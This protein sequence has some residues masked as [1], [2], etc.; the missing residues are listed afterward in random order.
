VFLRTVRFQFCGGFVPS[1]IARLQDAK[2]RSDAEVRLH[3]KL[4][5]RGTPKLQ[6]S[7]RLNA[8]EFYSS[9]CSSYSSARYMLL[10]VETC[11]WTRK[12]YRMNI[13]PE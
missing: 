3:S 11:N 4:N 10:W 13:F 1:G 9:I 8:Y 2:R 12:S 6:K 5:P 7:Y